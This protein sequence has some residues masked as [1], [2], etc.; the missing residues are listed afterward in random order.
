VN[1]R[2][3]RAAILEA[4]ARVAPEVD[5]AALDPRADLREQAEIDSMDVLSFVLG[6]AERTGVEIPE[7]DYG[8]IATLDDCV[9]YVAA[10]A[11]G[12]SP[13]NP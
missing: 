13:G 4:L 11:S 1:E 6:I 8:R 5:G 10:R 7:A 12:S 3:I 9:A 2:E